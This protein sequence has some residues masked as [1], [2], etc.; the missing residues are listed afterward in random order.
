[1]CSDVQSV[2]H[3]NIVRDGDYFRDDCECCGEFTLVAYH[4]NKHTGVEFALCE[5][6][7]EHFEA[8]E[9]GTGGSE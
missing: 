4:V 7:V 9:T 5:C 8:L 6:C 3:G 2:Y 1:M